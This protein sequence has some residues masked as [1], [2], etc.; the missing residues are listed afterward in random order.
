MSNL[1]RVT[2]FILMS[3]KEFLSLSRFS[4]SL[5]AGFGVILGYICCGIYTPSISISLGFVS[6]T[7]L[8]MAG[9]IHN[10]LL[11]IEVDTL[12]HP[13]RLLVKRPELTSSALVSSYF[14]YA[15]AVGSAYIISLSHGTLVGFMAALLWIYN[16]KLKRVPLAGN[17][18]ISLLCGLAIYFAECPAIISN[19]LIPFLFAFIA[20]FA[21]EI[22]KDIQDMKSDYSKGHITLPAMW[23]AAPSAKLAGVLMILILFLLPFPVSHFSY[24]Y[25]FALI[26]LI[27]VL[28]PL[29]IALR[30]MFVNPPRWEKSQKYLK[31]MMLGGMLAIAAG[32]ILGS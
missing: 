2:K 17:I 26:S 3:L 13:D 19:T 8:A 27:F 22:V 5:M 12:A 9:N 18:A 20:T 6:I 11:D 21:R 14:L 10:D 29:F 31:H 15:A 28:I 32:K 24:H 16:V 30:S 23:G 1:I 25:S 4:N 7:L